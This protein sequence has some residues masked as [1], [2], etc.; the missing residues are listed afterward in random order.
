MDERS[1]VVTYH[2]NRT[3]PGQGGGGPHGVLP[4]PVTCLRRDEL[5]RG[6]YAVGQPT[7]GAPSDQAAK[8]SPRHSR[9][10]KLRR[11]HHPG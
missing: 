10:R 7:P 6:E 1:A 4:R 5:S 8:L 3:D 2:G 9:C 11:R